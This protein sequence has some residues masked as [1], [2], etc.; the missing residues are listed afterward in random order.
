M[1][2]A[3]QYWVGAGLKVK[4]KKTNDFKVPP[5]FQRK[6]QQV[7]VLK[8]SFAALTPRRQRGYILYCS[9]AKQ[10]KTR[11]ARVEK[12]MKRILNGKDWMIS[13]ICRSNRAIQ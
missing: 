8:R 13:A 9:G 10:S 1:A 11:E 3:R 6:L 4:L 5:E 7:P 2:V 12:S